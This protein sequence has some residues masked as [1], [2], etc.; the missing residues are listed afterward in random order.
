MQQLEGG[1][2][3]VA[4]VVCQMLT[5]EVADLEAE[6]NA[7]EERTR[8]E[9]ARSRRR[10]VHMSLKL[11]AAHAKA[12]VATAKAAEADARLFA[13]TAEGERAGP[14]HVLCRRGASAARHRALVEA[15]AEV[16]GLRLDREGVLSL[17]A[18]LEWAWERGLRRVLLEAG[19]TLQTAMIEQGFVDQLRVYTGSVNGGRG[20]SLAAFLEPRLLEDV[21]HREVGEDAVLEAFIRSAS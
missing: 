3:S 6:V 19:P 9:R 17:R 2:A 4:G 20:A 14:V 7:C 21:L 1:G 10:M 13:A 5:P 15:G 8:D 12:R 16:H 18:V 11:S